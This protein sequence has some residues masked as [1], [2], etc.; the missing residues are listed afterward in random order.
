MWL[1]IRQFDLAGD[2]TAAAWV[3]PRLSNEGGARRH[4]LT[5]G[6]LL[7]TG[8]QA[9]ARVL[10]P[11][12]RATA[13]G[14]E[15]VRWKEVAAWS[16]RP[17]QRDSGFGDIAVAPP[18]ASAVAPWDGEAPRD[19]TLDAA[20][21]TTLATMLAGATT[22]PER[23]WFAFWDGLGFLHGPPAMIVVGGRRAARW[24]DRLQLWRSARLLRHDY[25]RT[26]MAPRFRIGG[27]DYVLLH[28]PLTVVAS[29]RFGPLRWFESPNLWWPEDRAWF[30]ATDIDATSTY[31]ACDA[32]C[33][34]RLAASPDLEV[35]AAERE[36]PLDLLRFD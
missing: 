5:V 2:V 16:G 11:V 28:G 19:G 25:A 21:A 10:H 8:Y 27:L 13:G 3:P 1:G 24:R 17:L 7:P 29:L 12:T 32:A 9:Y 22:T 30:V 18:G 6:S 31:V 26:A 20:G 36:A 35:L 33:F 14:P 15:P 4:G 23:C 34:D